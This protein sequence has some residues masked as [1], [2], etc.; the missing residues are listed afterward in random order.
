MKILLVSPST[1][2]SGH[3]VIY[4]TKL[5]ENIAKK[6]QVKVYV[7]NDT[8]LKSDDFNGGDLIKS[9]I[10]FSFTSR[11][12]YAKYGKL[13][14]I[15]RGFNR[16]RT[17]ISFFK[18]LLEFVEKE[19]FDVIHVLDAEYVSYIYLANRIKNIL[20]T[21]LIYTIHASDF[22]FQSI[23]VSTIYKSIVGRFLKKALVNTDYVVC[24]G[25]WIKERLVKSFPKIEQKILGYNYPSNEYKEYNKA[26]IRNKLGIDQEAKIISFLGMIRRDKRIEFA[27]EVIKLLPQEYKLLVAGSLSD[28][29]EEYIRKMMKEM[30][31]EEKVISDFRYLSLEEFDYYFKAGNIFLSTHSDKF[32]SASGP[33]SD[34][35]T[36]GLPV[37]VTPGGQLEQYV[38]AEKVGI[39]PNGSSPQDFVDAIED[40]FGNEDL[41]TKKV[42]EASKR[43]SWESFA[44]KHVEVYEKICK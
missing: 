26:E 28:Y 9:T 4:L 35:R 10:E 42:I 5:Y 7:P 43:F 6:H 27:F 39:A 13:G 34:S 18:G 30:G 41:Y 33:V 14:Q 1:S 16:L 40:I 8:K 38:N 3:G 29:K 32:P 19:K 17:G 21:K 24:H 23:S 25:D 44:N 11:E 12:K 37:V 22:N 20:G 15:I 2:N 31:I 36:Y